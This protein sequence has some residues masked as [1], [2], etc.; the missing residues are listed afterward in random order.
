M[1]KKKKKNQSPCQELG[2]SQNER[3]KKTIARCQNWDDKDVGVIRW[4]FYS[5]HGENAS[6]TTTHLKQ[7]KT[8]K[9]SG[10]KKV[11]AKKQ[12]IT[13][14]N[15]T[16]TLELKKYN[17]QNRKQMGELNSRMETEENQWAGRCN[18]RNYANWATEENN[19]K[20]ATAL[21]RASGTCGVTAEDPTCV[22][23]A[24]K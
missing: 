24:Q 7:M 16:K 2:R 3:E 1:S 13:K 19:L 4:G 9:D 20:K 15:H 17:S 8:Y 12:T 18:K 21:K 10:K 6:W 14:K 11:S 23:G 22:A 5:R